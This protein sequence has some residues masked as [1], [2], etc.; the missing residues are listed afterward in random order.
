MPPSASTPIKGWLTPI[1]VYI[2]D[3]AQAPVSATDGGT[4]IPE[5][6]LRIDGFT[7][8]T[9]AKWAVDWAG[10]VPTEPM[11][12]MWAPSSHAHTS[13][14]RTSTTVTRISGANVG[15]DSVAN[16]FAGHRLFG[17]LNSQTASFTDYGLAITSSAYVS[18]G[19]HDLTHASHG[20]ASGS[21]TL[22]DIHGPST[23]M[24]ARP[25]FALVN[26]DNSRIVAVYADCVAGTLK[27]RYWN[28]S[29]WGSYA[30]IS[31][32]YFVPEAPVLV[33]LSYDGAGTITIAAS[34]NGTEVSSTTLSATPNQPLTALIAGDGTSVTPM[35][36]WSG[37]VYE[38]G[39]AQTATSR[40]SNVN[41]W[42]NDFVGRT[43]AYG[44]AAR[45]LRI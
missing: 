12:D 44:R 45:A 22:I 19:V 13:A 42:G 29:T 4:T 26:A 2:G 35:E 27:A 23:S 6:S 20:Q 31:G 1:G 25:L 17:N 3:C 41:S 15:L 33:S 40:L 14:T 38:T 39:T 7:L 5:T 18:T 36:W 10:K 24:A 28:G 9:S 34:V 30:T 21:W 43:R 11:W 32:F 16:A 37:Q 8:G